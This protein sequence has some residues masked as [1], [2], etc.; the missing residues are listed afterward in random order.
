MRG[1]SFRKCSN[2]AYI[3][4]HRAR[5]RTSYRL[6]CWSA[7]PLVRW[8]AGPLVRWSAD[9]LVRWS[10][11]PPPPLMLAKPIVSE[12]SPVRKHA[13]TRFD[14][15]SSIL[16]DLWGA[17]IGACSRVNVF[18]AKAPREEIRSAMVP[19]FYFS[20]RSASE[21]SMLHRRREILA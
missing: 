19:E 5:S 17:L 18:G 6:V 20:L 1:P 10:A 9:P 11:A 8:S 7:G 15:P 13:N 2:D 21:A 3:G 14:T 4:R 12:E 16:T